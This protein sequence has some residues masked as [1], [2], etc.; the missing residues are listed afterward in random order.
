MTRGK[1]RDHPRMS[2]RRTMRRLSPFA[3]AVL[4]ALACAPQARAATSGTAAFDQAVDELIQRGYPQ[5]LEKRMLSFGSPFWGHSYAGTSYHKAQANAIACEMRGSG[6]ARHAREPVPVDSYDLIFAG[7]KIGTSL[8]HWHRLSQGTPPT[9]SGGVS[10]N[11]VYV[12]N[13]LAEDYVAAGDV[14]G[15]IV[16]V[17][18]WT[19]MWWWDVVAKEAKLHGATAII[20]QLDDRYP[21]ALVNGAA[22]GNGPST[23][24]RTDLPM[25]LL[26]RNDAASIK[27]MLSEGS[28]S[29]TVTLE[30]AVRS[31]EDGGSPRTTSLASSREPG[32]RS[33]SLCIARVPIAT[34]GQRSTIPRRSS[35]A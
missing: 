28:V 35:T 25:V 33:S 9:G 12:H 19:A 11:I 32:S 21:R 34:S 8:G 30:A 17:D 1:I 5:R 27:Q 13:G 10:G 3:A 7:V 14:T 20:A 4:V 24:D 26:S 15:K 16:L 2:L 18:I 6:L 22:F 23:L 29:G 31:A